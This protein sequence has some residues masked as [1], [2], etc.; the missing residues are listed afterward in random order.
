[1]RNIDR[2][3]IENRPM[4]IRCDDLDNHFLISN[5]SGQPYF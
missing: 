4:I 1:M 2:I 5:R 3:R